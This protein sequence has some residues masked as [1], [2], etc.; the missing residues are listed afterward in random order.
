MNAPQPVTLYLLCGKI[1]AG[2]STLAR[3]LSQR[4][5]TLLI[6]MDDWMSVLYPTENRTIEDFAQLSKRLR[7]AMG[8]HVVAILRQGVSVVMDFPANTVMWRSWLRSL[9]DAARLAQRN[10]SG[11]HPYQVDEATYDQ[12]M[13][14]FTYPSAEEGCNVVVHVA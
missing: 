13:S 4:P 5:A 1:A 12:F 6:A 14:Y 9:A 11:D 3:Q 8:P 7:A 10:A 2:K